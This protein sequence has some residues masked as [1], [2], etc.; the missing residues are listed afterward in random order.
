[1]NSRNWCNIRWLVALSLTAVVHASVAFAADESPS[2]ATRSAMRALKAGDYP[3]AI[4][5]Y[6]TAKQQMPESPE[7]AYNLGVA[8]YR[9]GDFQRAAGAFR[10]AVSISNDGSIRSRAIYNMGN[11]AYAESLKALQ[12]QGDP[13]QSQNQLQQ[14]TDLLKEALDQYKKAMSAD[15]TDEDARANAELSHKFLKQLQQLQEQQ[16]QQQQQ[17]QEN[18]DQQQQQSSPSSQGD[19]NQQEQQSQDQQQQQEQQ[20]SSQPSS[21]QQQSPQ[22]DA[23]QQQANEAED[24]SGQQQQQEQLENEIESLEEPQPKDQGQHVQH[25]PDAKEKK[26]MTRQEAERL[27]QAVRDKEQKR[28]FEQLRR[29]AAK[30]APAEKD[31]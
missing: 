4:E 27:L 9:N 6:E 16:Q 14:A 23:Q 22:P 19:Q 20:A 30:Y 26:T 2:D 10:D 25:K 21:E 5:L 18:Q 12:T 3:R 28:R 13:T 7:I 15:P 11:A 31:W 17:Q 24:A 29:E 1:M 8:H